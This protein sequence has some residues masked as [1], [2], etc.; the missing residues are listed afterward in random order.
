MSAAIQ[1][2]MPCLPDCVVMPVAG[3]SNYRSGMVL[4]AR[5]IVCAFGRPG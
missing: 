2:T 4:A 1:I 3:R 5:Q